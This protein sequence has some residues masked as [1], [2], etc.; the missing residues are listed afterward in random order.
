[1][2]GQIKA[3]EEANGDGFLS[4]ENAEQIR[5]L[6]QAAQKEIDQLEE[7]LGRSS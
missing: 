7:S 4:E 5:A 1:M 3:I 2:A 6:R